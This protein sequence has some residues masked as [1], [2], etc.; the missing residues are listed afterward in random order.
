[1]LVVLVGDVAANE[2]TAG[3]VVSTLTLAGAP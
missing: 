1:M 2:L 3:L